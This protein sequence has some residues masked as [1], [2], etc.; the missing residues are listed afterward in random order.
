MNAHAVLMCLAMS[1][2]YLARGSDSAS[3]WVHHLCEPLEVSKKGPYVRMADGALATADDQGFAKSYDEGRTWSEPQPVCAGL[4]P[5]EPA[6]YYLLRT[7]N[8]VLVLVYLN[9]EG[10]RFS[11]DSER[12]EPGECTLEVWAIRSLDGGK[13]WVDNQRLLDG[14]NANFF[15]LIETSAGRIVVPLQHLVPDPGR[16]VVC[17]FW[18]DDDGLTWHRSNWIDL[19]GHGHHDGAFEPTVAE[20]PDGRLLM[21][22]RTNLDCFWQA[23]SEDG[24]R[25]WRTIQP[26]AID[27]SSA[28][29]HLL[30]LA[31]GR[32]VLVWNRLNPEGGEWPK[33]RPTPFHSEFPASWHREELSIAFSEDGFHWSEPVVIARQPGGQLSYPYLFEAQPGEIWVLVGFAMRKPWQDPWPL[34]L[35]L[36]ERDFAR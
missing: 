4:N 36:R 27:A 6:S 34:R 35:R 20:L 16:L 17:S 18:S 5:A 3:R 30:R 12:N 13:T 11:W 26:S 8:D 25:Y 14:Y 31:S 10:R 28:P 9:F 19:G 32:Y 2:P 21:L 7:R 23:I 24:G 1:V 33:T 22:I 29:G 15:G